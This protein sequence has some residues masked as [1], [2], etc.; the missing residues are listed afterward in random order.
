MRMK[1]LKEKTT[2]EAKTFGATASPLEKFKRQYLVVGP[3]KKEFVDRGSIK[4]LSEDDLV[5][6]KRHGL[7][8]FRYA[9]SK[10]AEERNKLLEEYNRQVKEWESQYTRLG[11]E[12]V[13]NDIAVILT[14]DDKKRIMKLGFANWYRD[15]FAPKA[16]Y[17]VPSES[18]LKAYPSGFEGMTLTPQAPLNKEAVAFSASSV[19]SPDKLGSLGSIDG[20]VYYPAKAVVWMRPEDIGRIP[21]EWKELWDVEQMRLYAT[22]AGQPARTVQDSAK[23]KPEKEAP[24]PSA[25]L[26]EHIP[27]SKFAPPRI[28]KM[29][30]LTPGVK[31]V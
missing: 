20:Y 8:R 13:H 6:L 9:A 27:L 24:V 17:A 15:E 30:R 26:K 16:K 28:V 18:F 2:L 23:W 22:H 14:N 31:R 19:L 25:R 12:L 11:D 7:A 21:P 5:F 4:N 3:G 29:F 10:V 1:D